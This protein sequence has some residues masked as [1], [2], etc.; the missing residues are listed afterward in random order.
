[1]D[2]RRQNDK[3]CP[4]T[5]TEFV[6]DVVSANIGPRPIC[7]AAYMFTLN[8]CW[9]KKIGKEC[10]FKAFSMLPLVFYSFIVAFRKNN[11][12]EYVLNFIFSHFQLMPIIKILCWVPAILLELWKPDSG[13]HLIETYFYSKINYSCNIWAQNLMAICLHI[14]QNWHFLAWLSVKFK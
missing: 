2:S 7:Q 9:H 1:M 13:R 10:I 3:T 8:S 5:C 6:P 4:F 14:I 12:C 11:F